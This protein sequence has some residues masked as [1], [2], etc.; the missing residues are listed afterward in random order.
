MSRMLPTTQELLGIF[1]SI[2]RNH[3]W[4]R[5]IELHAIPGKPLC[6]E[7]VDKDLARLMLLLSYC[8]ED[9]KIVSPSGDSYATKKEV[10]Q[11]LNGNRK[12]EQEALDRL[13]SL[14]KLVEADGGYFV[15]AVNGEAYKH[16]RKQH[17]YF[18][19]RSV[20]Q[21]TYIAREGSRGEN[22]Q[23]KTTLGRMF[24]LIPYLNFYY[25]ILCKNPQ[26]QSLEKIEPLSKDEIC[27]IMKVSN[28][29]SGHQIPEAEL[30]VK[31]VEGYYEML[32]YCQTEYGKAVY[33]MN[34][35][36]CQV[37]EVHWSIYTL[38]NCWKWAPIVYD[39]DY[40]EAISVE[41][42]QK[43][44]EDAEHIESDS[45]FWND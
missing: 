22:I 6:P 18:L 21:S 33:V 43:N 24:R 29:K 14:E 25:N 31:T 16:P 38:R 15:M 9:R 30:T 3:K 26:E 27:E 42:E 45:S 13:L 2:Y 44:A 32:R 40:I 20:I 23:M 8:E 19:K 1:E 34:P 4:D 10:L 17:S 28:P 37:A 36:L 5:T 41:E 35:E 11:M 7:L 39:I 12:T